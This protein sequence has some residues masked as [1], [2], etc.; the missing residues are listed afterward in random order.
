M[1]G[2]DG[3][4]AWVGAGPGAGLGVGVAW[5]GRGLDGAGPR[6]EAG[7]GRA[8]AHGSREGRRGAQGGAQDGAER[9]WP[10]EGLDWG[11][12]AGLG[13]ERGKVPVSWKGQTSCCLFCGLLNGQLPSHDTTRDQFAFCGFCRIA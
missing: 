4:G 8:G 1:R 3:G 9:S 7:P 11:V 5:M 13:L 10:G 2:V 6:V 12:R